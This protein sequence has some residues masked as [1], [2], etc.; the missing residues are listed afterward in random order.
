M[1]SVRVAV[2]RRAGQPWAWLMGLALVALLAS[3]CGVAG[4]STAQAAG[5]GHPRVGAYV[6]VRSGGA[7]LVKA[8]GTVDSAVCR[9][10]ARFPK[11]ALDLNA[12]LISPAII[13]TLITFR[14][15]IEI[16]GYHH[17]C[18]WWLAPDFPV[19]A[20]DKSFDAYWHKGLQATGGFIAGAPREYQ[21]NVGRKPTIDEMARLL[22]WGSQRARVR[23]FFGD[24]FSP[25]ASWVPVGN[26]F[27]DQVR[28]QNMSAMVRRLREEMPYGFRCY[29][30]GTGAERCGLDGTLVE[31]FP[32]A[33]VTGSFANALKQKDG[34]WL[35][36][37]GTFA[38][39]RAMR[40]ALG[41]ACLTGAT[42]TYGAQ[43]VSPGGQPWP[44]TWWFDEWSVDANGKPDYTGKSVG[45]LGDALSAWVKMS[46]GLYIRFFQHGV[47]GVNPTSSLITQQALN[48]RWKR[49]GQTVPDSVLSVP[50]KDA[51]FL[52]G[53]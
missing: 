4:P 48:P 45:W 25:V 21:V 39:K 47:V 28:V 13:P 26:E 12:L 22:V 33:L 31:G 53:E 17:T 20:S 18:S 11:V 40:F 3:S 49:I 9:D 32:D 23:G 27:T 19:N 14:A 29:G 1:D 52:W 8:D 42:L 38:D 44:G 41:T 34:D 24:Y 50:A 2:W 37:E 46:S 35:K 43:E 5:N 16:S 15:D 6:G 7:P 30:N 51:V 36:S 10:F